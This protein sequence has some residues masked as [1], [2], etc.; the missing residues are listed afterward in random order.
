[1]PTYL[2]AHRFERAF[3]QCLVDDE[4]NENLCG[5]SDTA[6]NRRAELNVSILLGGSCSLSGS[7]MIFVILTMQEV[8]MRITPK[9]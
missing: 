1:M 7:G 9:E 3:F 8:E 4:V 5:S 6:I 2:A